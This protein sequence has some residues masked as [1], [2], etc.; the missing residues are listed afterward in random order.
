MASFGTD[1]NTCQYGYSYEDQSF[2]NGDLGVET[3]TIGSTTSHQV[4]QR[5]CLGV[6]TIMMVHLMRQDQAQSA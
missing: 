4:S 3:L 1:K 2:A 6:G 5:L